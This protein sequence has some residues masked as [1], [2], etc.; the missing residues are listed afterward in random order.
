MPGSRLG[1]GNRSFWMVFHGFIWPLQTNAGRKPRIHATIAYL[2][3]ILHSWPIS[4]SFIPRFHC[5]CLE[6]C[7]KIS[8][9]NRMRSSYQVESR[10]GN[11]MR[12]NQPC[13]AH[14]NIPIKITFSTESS[15][16]N[17]SANLISAC[18]CLRNKLLYCVGMGRVAQSV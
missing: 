16:W 7:R 4:H 18:I 15:D 5:L 6:Q 13:V 14:T 8:Q 10:A 2:Q 3:M 17:I 11:R 1:T 9:K 12:P